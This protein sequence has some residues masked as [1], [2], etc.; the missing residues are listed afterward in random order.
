MANSLWAEETPSKEPKADV[1]LNEETEPSGYGRV[2]DRLMLIAHLSASYT[3]SDLQ[4]SNT[5]S[6]GSISGVIAPTYRL[7][8]NKFLILMYDGQYY[9]KREFYSDDIGPRQRSEFQRHTITPMLRIDFGKG[10]RYSMT[11]SFFY[12][13]TY[14]KDI[15]PGGWSEGLYNYYDVGA[16]LDFDMRKLGFGGGE[17]TLKVGVQFY[18]RDYPNY[19]SL[20]DLAT[21][22]GVEEDEKDYHGVI[23]RARYNWT[24]KL[25]FSWGAEYSLLYKN[26][27]DKKVVNSNGLLT[28]T[29]QRDY[30]HSLDLKCWYVLDNIDGRFRVGLDLNGSLKDSNQNY[31]DAM[32]TLDPSD[33]VSLPDFYDYRS[34][35]IRPNISYTFAL[36]PLTSS[37]AYSYQK[38][39]YI[40]RRAR[41]SNG[42]YKNDKQWETL[43]EV[44]IGLSY[45]LTKNWALMAQWQ[46][47][48]GRSNNDD[49]S[50]YRYDYRINNYSMGISYSF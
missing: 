46:H 30:L 36:F 49:E 23:T 18:R 1:L 44:E 47:I 24:Q 8:H 19:V 11:P 29:E 9:K 27:D 48:V 26:L 31:F 37:F 25:G 12:T 4:G 39:D 14:N 40:D 2:T 35:R 42:I 32:G 41:F 3:L 21:G 20:L 17:G 50:V 13:A 28:S 7:N 34:Y 16:G 5:L 43:E 33:N 6:G 22:I 45:D 15:E 38:S 10:S